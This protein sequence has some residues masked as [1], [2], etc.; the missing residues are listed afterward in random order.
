MSTR[1]ATHSG[2]W[3]SG[4][5]HALHTQITGFFAN[6]VN[7]IPRARVLVGPHAGF[8]YSGHRLAETFSAWDT[9]HVQRVFIL[10]PS[11]H[12]YFRNHVKVSHYAFYDTPIGK[13]PV[14]TSINHHLTQGLHSGKRVFQYMDA[15]TDEDEHSFEM[16][17]PFIKHRLDIDQ[18]SAGVT[19]VPIM[20]SGMDGP[21]ADAVCRALAPYFSDPA[22]TFVVSSDFCHWGER[23]NYTQYVPKPLD[24]TAVGID[25]VVAELM[26]VR[27]NKQLDT[28]EIHES[29]EIL[30]RV[31]MHIASH[32][33]W[34]DWKRYIEKTRNTIC[35][36]KPLMV[37]MRLL[38]GER[39][40][41]AGSAF[42]WLGYSQS[43]SVINVHDSSVSYASG[44][45]LA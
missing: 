44:Y 6:K 11:H 5:R 4:S 2:S 17:C 13:L 22:N 39:A 19:I 26:T 40:A 12:V 16:H 25:D 35:G 38:E 36:E 24:Y 32:G 14:D 3:Y 9:D 43:S 23:F 29:I 10:G 45:A 31:A 18:K 30:D 37:V 41:A 27:S 8:S 7:P 20:I 21:C 33:T 1:P 34:K 28:T 15:E 42:H